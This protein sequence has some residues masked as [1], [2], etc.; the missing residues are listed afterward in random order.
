MDVASNFVFIEYMPNLT[1]AFVINAKHALE[2]FTSSFGLQIKEH[3]T[4]NHGFQANDFVQDCVSQRQPHTLWGVGAHHQSCVECSAW[5]IGMG[6]NYDAILH[7]A[8][9]ERGYA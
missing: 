8:L 2:R 7:Y 5:P 9:A 6:Q 4:D 3:L 1:A